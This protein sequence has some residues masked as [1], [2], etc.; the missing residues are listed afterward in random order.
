ML[1]TKTTFIGIDPTAGK[2][3]FVY[4]AIDHQKDLLALG[5]GD[6]DT[7]LAFVAGQQQAVVAINA[8][9]Q[10]NRGF[11]EEDFFREKLKP[12]P[13]PGRWLGYRVAEYILVQCGIKIPR[14]PAKGEPS[15]GWMEMGFVTYQRLS[16]LGFVN[17]TGDDSPLQMLEV[18]PHGAYTALLD[19]IPFQ[20]KA[21]EGRIQRQLVLYENDLNVP[22]PMRMFEEITRHKLLQGVLPFDQLYSSEEL[23]AL[24]AALTA[25]I[26][27]TKPESITL[28]GE[29]TEG[30][31]IFPVPS[32]KKMYS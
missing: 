24:V 8:P 2:N 28:V 21:L 14:T 29:R 11:M 1:F 30:Q 25:Y 20:K 9:S 23:D 3:P 6:L 4:A 17:Y 13:R 27:A 22:D 26:A 12:Q 10:P 19:R 7:I 31:V 18:Y 15:P 5:E 16:Q 32:L